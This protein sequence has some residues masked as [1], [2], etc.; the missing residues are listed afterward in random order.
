MRDLVRLVVV[1]AA[2]VVFA[3]LYGAPKGLLAQPAMGR[4][5]QTW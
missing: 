3:N 4:P 2:V 1:V 5:S